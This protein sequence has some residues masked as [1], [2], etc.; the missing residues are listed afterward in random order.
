MKLDDLILVSIDD[1]V[2]EP[3]DMFEGHVPASYA[4]QA[5]KVVVD[6]DGVEQWIFQGQRAGSTGLNA[7]V[8]WP[9]E[10]WGLD[11]SS[12]AEMR[13]GAY[14]VH[15]RVRDMNRNGILASMCFPSFA[16]FAASFFHGAPDKD[17]STMMLKAY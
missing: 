6:G 16:G 12:L 9:K 7:V 8:G 15:E 3:A 17:L 10:D 13:P 4:D 1:H 5:P 11:P 2:V 14:D